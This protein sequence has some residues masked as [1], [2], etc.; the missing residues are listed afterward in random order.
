M[1]L[2]FF[3]FFFPKQ[4][5][6]QLLLTSV[7]KNCYG[8]LLLDSATTVIS[9]LDSAT[10]NCSNDS[11][12]YAEKVATAQ[13]HKFQSKDHGFVDSFCDVSLLTFQ[14]L[15]LNRTDMNMQIHG[16]LEITFL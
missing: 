4:I 13:V 10:N 9:A 8:P 14:A 1:A 6:H 5:V 15:V 3:R 7:A 11:C 2:E 16:F 12:T